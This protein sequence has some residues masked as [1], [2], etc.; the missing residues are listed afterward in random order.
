MK[1]GRIFHPL[2]RV[3]AG[4][5]IDKCVSVMR[6]EEAKVPVGIVTDEE[7]MYELLYK[8][9]DKEGYEARRVPSD[10]S[11]AGDLALII[12]APTRNPSRSRRWFDNL[13][14]TK[15][16]VLIVQCCD[17]D[18]ADVDSDVVLVK[19]RPLN[20]RQLSSTIKQTLEKTRCSFEKSGDGLGNQP[21][22]K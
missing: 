15:P 1:A 2:H 7:A 18:Y 3:P 19:D 10:T 6:S 20:L 13:N 22:R 5:T 14:T 12:L 8:F 16:A 11:D 21:A 9:L 4:T 17:E